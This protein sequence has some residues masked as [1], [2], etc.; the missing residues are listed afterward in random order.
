[1]VYGFMGDDLMK[2]RDELIE[3]VDNYC[4]SRDEMCSNCIFKDDSHRCN[5]GNLSIDE[6][7]E[8]M[9]MIKESEDK[10]VNHPS[11]YNREGAM[12]TIDEMIEL[13]GI[14][15]TMAFCKLNAWK[16]R[17]RAMEKNG[18]KDMKK[19][20][21]YIRKYAELKVRLKMGGTHIGQN[22]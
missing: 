22:L 13:F 12:E 15:D 7:E 2:K 1:M 4:A 5:Y 16:Y 11:H 10:D 20:D 21:W 9:E 3:F 19:S 14:E 6:L 17:S 8:S 18:E